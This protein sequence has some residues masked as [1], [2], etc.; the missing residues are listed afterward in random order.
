MKFLRL[1]SVIINTTKISSIQIHN[2][3][4][5]INVIS[6]TFGGSFIGIFGTI[7]ST[8]DQIKICKEKD[9]TDYQTIT[10]WINNIK[11]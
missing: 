9:T 7:C 4:Y 6:H 2:D 8:K 3:K 1:S 5:Y 11:N 10:N